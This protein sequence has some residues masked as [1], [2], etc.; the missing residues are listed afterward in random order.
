MNGPTLGDHPS[1]DLLADLAADALPTQDARVVE[2]HVLGCASCSDLLADAEQLRGLLARSSV[3]PMPDAVWQRLERALGAE[4][5][6]HTAD[7]R[8]AAEPQAAGD[9]RVTGMLP[10]PA[11]PFFSAELPIPAEQDTI[12]LPRTPGQETG[13][14]VAEVRSAPEARGASEPATGDLPRSERTP[15][16]WDPGSPGQ[17]TGLLPTTSSDVV[18]P[19]SKRL[20]RVAG[21]QQ[22]SRRDSLAAQRS[23]APSRW[24]NPIWRGV[25]AAAVL[26]G[27]SAG[28]YGIV[29]VVDSGSGHPVAAASAPGAFDALASTVR[30]SGTDYSLGRLDTQIRSLVASAGQSVM[31]DRDTTAPAQPHSTAGAARGG[32]QEANSSAVTATDGKAASAGNGVVR[33]AES[34]QP[35]QLLR[36]GPALQACLAAI[37]AGSARP[38]AVDLATYQGREAAVIVLPAV[39]GGYEVWVVSRTCRPGADGTLA[40]RVIAPGTTPTP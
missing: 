8:V 22:R 39:N 18:L 38:V 40:Y 13:P 15:R 30:Q 33:G 32:T 31:Y 34:S 35:G 11:E 25:A 10:I 5:G 21:G 23:D 19:Q 26:L 16:G 1:L 3:A 7:P 4:A 20:R 9:R 14:W 28:G 2:S 6:R 12:H 24:T 37:D 17:A 36:S 27:L 29:R